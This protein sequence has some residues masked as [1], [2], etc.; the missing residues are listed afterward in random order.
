MIGHRPSSFSDNMPGCLG[1]LFNRYLEEGSYP[2]KN[3]R[4]LQ[5][6]G[7]NTQKKTL[8]AGQIFCWGNLQIAEKNAQNSYQH[9]TFLVL[10]HQ[11]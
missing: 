9:L 3:A 6:G 1:H 5:R 10:L 7:S 11:A 2:M 4:K 8:L